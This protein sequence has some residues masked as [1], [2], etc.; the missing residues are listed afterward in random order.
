MN[1]IIKPDNS[2][3]ITKDT[4]VGGI[5]LT[6]A[7]WGSITA[8]NIAHNDGRLQ[9]AKIDPITLVPYIDTAAQL[10]DVQKAKEIEIRDAANI[11]VESIIKPYHDWEQKSWFKQT[12]EAE[13]WTASNMAIT[14]Y[15][16]AAVAA[17]KLIDPAFTKAMFV[18]NV[19]A[20]R[21]AFDTAVGTI[22]GKQGALI[23]KIYDPTATVTGVQ[24]IKW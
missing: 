7:Q 1:I 14:P 21:D 24:A 16:D 4:V 9:Y 18:A 19:L 3:Y 17:R 15:I 8:F 11:A 5:T 13:A 2:Y 22:N 6:Q 20:K 12:S 10:I 23:A